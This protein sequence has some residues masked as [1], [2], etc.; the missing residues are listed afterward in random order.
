M[1]RIG[2]IKELKKV[3]RIGKIISLDLL[4][5]RK[6]EGRKRDGDKSQNRCPVCSQPIE[7]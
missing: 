7:T 2:K 6:E 1:N 4:A 5:K 3:P